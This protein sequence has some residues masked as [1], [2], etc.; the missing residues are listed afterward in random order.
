MN[1]R[2]LFISYYYH[3]DIG[4]GALRAKSIVDSL[5]KYGPSDVKIDVLTT[6]PNRY[7]S[8]DI[9]AAQLE[10]NGKLTIRRFQLPKHQ[11][12]IFDQI[13]AFV[14]F[15]F[16]VQKFIYKKKWDIVVATSGRLF[17]ASLAKLVS[18][19]VSAKLY[20]DIRDLFTDTIKHIQ[21]N[22]FFRLFMPLLYSIEKWTF[23]YA[24]KINVVSSAFLPYIKKIAPNVPISTYTN[25]V[26]NF[27]LKKN[28]INS[29]VHNKPLVLYVGNIGDGQSLNKII[30]L[31]ANKLKDINFKIIGDGSG[32]KLLDNNNYILQNNLQ[33][34]KP[35][36]RSKLFNEYKKADILFL[37][38]NHADSFK[39]VLPSKIFEYAATGKP[40]LAGVKGYSAKFLKKNIKGV[41][42][43]NPN[44][45]TKMQ[46]GLRKLLNGPKVFKRQNFCK[47]FDRD[48]IIKKLTTDIV[49]LLNQ[50]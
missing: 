48:K 26:D 8:L 22:F 14:F 46:I 29:K 10:F 28:F 24:S 37:H 40:I 15:F 2:I 42:I 21:Q 25:G 11:N 3:P 18:K 16:N 34:L 19:Q 13:I 17:T 12:G 9:S 50:K 6:V 44:D 30:P 4:P 39:K 35:V 33:I 43:F 20:L 47:N 1:K 23:K 45:F 27:I 5:I 31:A 49:S 32:R 7:S 36:L 41:E 38:L